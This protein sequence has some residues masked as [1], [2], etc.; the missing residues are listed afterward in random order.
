MQAHEGCPW[1][2]YTWVYHLSTFHV[3]AWSSSAGMNSPNPL[4]LGDTGVLALQLRTMH[5][6]QWCTTTWSILSYMSTGSLFE[7]IKNDTWHSGQ[8]IL[9]HVEY[10]PCFGEEVSRKHVAIQSF[11]HTVPKCNALEHTTISYHFVPRR[12]ESW[13]MLPPQL[14]PAA[15]SLSSA[16]GRVQSDTIC[17]HH[18][19]CAKST[20]FEK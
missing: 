8:V 11:E 1:L 12:Q 17:H 9:E 18:P 6:A 7:H 14:V 5:D 19:L 16:C 15:W 20:C 13:S 10:E 2:S 3:S 4:C